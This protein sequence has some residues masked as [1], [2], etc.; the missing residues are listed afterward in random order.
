TPPAFPVVMSMTRAGADPVPSGSIVLWTVTFST[1]VTGVDASDFQL[2][3][4]GAVAG[5][6]IISVTG[7]GTT[8]TV[9]ASTGTGDGTLALSLIDDDS[10]V[11]G[12]LSLGGS[13]AGNGDFAGEA[14]TLGG[15]TL[16]P[17]LLGTYFDNRQL[18]DPP[19]GTRV[20]GPIDFDWGG[21]APGV[22]GIGA[23]QFSVRW[24]GTLSVETART[25]RFRTIS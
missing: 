1:A 16:T 10:I 18:I 8:W 20:D 4:G 21:G 5:A 22:A 15:C 25:Y 17:G 19:A 24:E 6:G 2:V 12:G 14:Y 7:G 3:P 23:D 11:G 13:G 9:S